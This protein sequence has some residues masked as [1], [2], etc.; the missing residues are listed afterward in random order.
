MSDKIL[1]CKIGGK[2]AADAKLLKLFTEDLGQFTAE[3]QIVL[4]HGGGKEV[5][6]LTEKLLGQ[7]PIF[8]SG[9]RQ[10]TPAEMDIVEMV[11]SGLVN[12]R[13]VRLLQSN[14]LNA[15]GLCGAD[16]SLFVSQ[17]LDNPTC[18]R[19]GK[20]I[21]VKP[22]LLK[23]LLANDFLPI[24]SSTSCDYEGNGLNINADE[25]ALEVAAALKAWGLIFISDI[26]GVLKD[27]SPIPLLTQDQALE[28]IKAGIISGGMIPKVESSLDALKRGVGR[29]IIGEYKQP[30]DLKALF[31]AEQGTTISL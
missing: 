4:V 8:K 15:V 18:Q 25:A 30:G 5:S 12:K 21:T 28:Q 31:I 13:L 22:L 10:T 19:T 17:S 29:V 20:I 9:L 23:L 26:P 7:K 14:G 1:V 6:Q 27:G 11:L 2:L 3:Y 24:I 16:G